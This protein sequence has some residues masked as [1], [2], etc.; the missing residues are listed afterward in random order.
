MSR[1]PSTRNRGRPLSP[2]ALV[3]VSSTLLPL[4]AQ[5]DLEAARAEL[6]KVFER[7]ANTT[8]GEPQRQALAAF[9]ARYEGQDLG[10]LSYAG[11]LQL[12]LQR[13]MRGA[14]DALEPFFTR[15]QTIA[16]DEHRNMAGRVFLASLAGAL[17]DA[18]L[19]EERLRRR[20]TLAT[21]LYDD[22]ATIARST[23]PLL[24]KDS[25]VK[26]R[27]GLRIALL[28]GAIGR[29]DAAAVDTF[30]ASL[31]AGDDAPRTVPAA[32][33]RAVAG[34][35]EGALKP[36][37][38]DGQ[39]APAWTAT[40]V[41]DPRP[42]G[43]VNALA[44]ADLRGKVVVLDFWATWCPPC[45][46]VVPH[47]VELQKA[48]PTDVAVVGLTR[49]YGRGMDFAPDAEKPHGGKSVSG[50]D[51]DGELAVNQRFTTAF[52]VNYPIAFVDAT[53][54]AQ[55]YHVTGI[56]T[57]FVL[58]RAGKVVGSVVGGNAAAV[59]ELVEK[60]LAGK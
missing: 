41:V 55:S 50:L 13:D 38:L 33:L 8:I 18:T 35:P 60:A 2:L 1:I 26:D 40:H 3:A 47:L 29:S 39:P 46:A 31:Y 48:H 56:P 37:D 30:A 20:A 21:R 49:F 6:D 54:A 24:A 59:D 23:A 44:L 34:A 15:Y 16:N 5:V 58:D 43:K 25:K 42:Q 17:R 51:Q 14:A 28:R 9:L 57:V 53:V 12:Y 52:A 45:R 32:R 7:P 36:A 4:A 27:A 22:L 10:P 11:A 19:D